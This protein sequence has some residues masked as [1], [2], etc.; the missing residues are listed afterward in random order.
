VCAIFA[1][2]AATWAEHFGAPTFSRYRKPGEHVPPTEQY[3]PKSAIFGASALVFPPFV[4]QIALWTGHAV[5]T[6]AVSVVV[7]FFVLLFPFSTCSSGR[8][9]KLCRVCQHR[10]NS[11]L[12]VATPSTLHHVA[13]S[14]VPLLTLELRSSLVLHAGSLLGKL[15]CVCTVVGHLD[16]RSAQC[17][18]RVLINLRNRAVCRNQGP[19]ASIF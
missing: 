5:A 3:L 11:L 6:G 17:F 8:S 15:S 9:A 10:V 7:T 4:S 16:S 13:E 1:P 12:A 19:A 18:I 2:R 14:L